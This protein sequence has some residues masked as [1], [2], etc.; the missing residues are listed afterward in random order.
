MK[1]L[2][3]GARSITNRDWVFYHLDQMLLPLLDETEVS[4]C[5]GGQVGVDRL[6]E[7]YCKI[8]EIDFWLFKPYN[9][10]DPSVD[11]TTKF[12]FKR[13]KQMVD[14]ADMII[15]FYDGKDSSTEDVLRYAAKR[16]K[17]RTIIAWNEEEANEV[18]GEVYTANEE[19]P[20]EED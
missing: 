6:I 5:S 1:I 3:T 4:I 13:N 19:Q 10:I 17:D 9:M 2:V 16:G 11:F 20:A 15:A 12:F 18:S 14:N 7:E 8:N